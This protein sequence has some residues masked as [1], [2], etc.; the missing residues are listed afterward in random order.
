MLTDG[1]SLEGFVCRRE[2]YF[3]PKGRVVGPIDAGPE[4]FWTYARAS[5]LT[6]DPV[7]WR[8]A[9]DVGRGLGLGDVGG[10]DSEPDLRAA[11]RADSPDYALLYGLLELHRATDRGEYLEAARTLGAALLDDRFRESTGA[12]VDDRNRARLDD[13]VPLS[14]LHLA[15]AIRGESSADLPTPVGAPRT[16]EGGV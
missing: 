3:G 15:A 12:F 4:F 16:P 8:A 9:R 11:D 2:G 6:D 14:L 13:P 7:C 10:P 5:R 1:L